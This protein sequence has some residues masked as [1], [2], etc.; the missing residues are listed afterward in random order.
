MIVMLSRPEISYHDS[1][2]CIMLRGSLDETA[3]L[4]VMT[5]HQTLIAT[6]DHGVNCEDGS[7]SMVHALCKGTAGLQTSFLSLLL[8]FAL[9]FL[10]FW[11]EDASR[12][13]TWDLVWRGFAAF[14][15]QAE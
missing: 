13:K 1:Y 12:L 8:E 10:A 3:Y 14:T 4:S 11:S 7:S 5:M 15:P 9:L 6:F 2:S